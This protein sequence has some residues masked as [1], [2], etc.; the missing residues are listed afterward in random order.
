MFEIH[1]T[2]AA[3]DIVNSILHRK[4]KKRNR[5]ESG[6]GNFPRDRRDSAATEDKPYNRPKR[7]SPAEDGTPSLRPPQRRYPHPEIPLHVLPRPNATVGPRARSSS[8][9]SDRFPAWADRAEKRPSNR[10]RTTTSSPTTSGS[11][12]KG[13]GPACTSTINCSKTGRQEAVQMRIAEVKAFQV[14]TRRESAG[15]S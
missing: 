9:C 1:A 8:F 11:P 13:R 6:F 4:L 5:N 14:A 2:K 15:R 7:H 10:S 3:W 12:R